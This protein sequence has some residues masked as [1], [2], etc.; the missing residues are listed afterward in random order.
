[1]RYPGRTVGAALLALLLAP[2]VALAS[3]S[4]SPGAP[5]D[6]AVGSGKNTFF[7]VGGENHVMVSAHGA[8]PDATGHVTARGDFLGDFKL[9]G[10]VTCLRAEG[11]RA[12]I[13]YRFKHAEGSLEPFEGGGVQVFI[14]DNGQPKGGEPVDRNAFDPPLPAGTFEPDQC[15]DPNRTDYD[16]IDSGN[17][18]VHDSPG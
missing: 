14:E 9:E 15:G 3:H 12:S 4:E 10:E 1:M 17:Y 2:V 7:Q 6:F 11:N 13:K 18:T 16:P 5:R 8:G